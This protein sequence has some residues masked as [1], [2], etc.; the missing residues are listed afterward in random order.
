MQLGIN[1]G[2]ASAQAHIDYYKS[3][4][5]GYFTANEVKTPEQVLE[6]Q[7]KEY[8]A[9]LEVKGEVMA[10]DHGSNYAS[11]LSTANHGIAALRQ[12]KKLISLSKQYHGSDHRRTKKLENLLVQFSSRFVINLDDSNK[13]Q[14][15]R[16]D[17][18]K[19]VAQGPV[20]EPRVI[21]E[22]KIMLMDADRISF[23]LGTPVI[24]HGLNNAAYLNEKIG[25]I[26]SFDTTA[27]TLRY[28]VHFE[29]GSITPKSVKGANLRIL[30]E[31]PDSKKG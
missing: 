14:V 29:D 7:K 5:R 26:R 11:A 19:C 15:L 4:F 18:A 30:F 3:K 21:G 13:Y 31:L 1:E 17:G 6:I 25:D 20:R 2:V 28:G 22:E 9:Y 24:C 10:I 23:T 12:V 27:E 8:E 16:Y